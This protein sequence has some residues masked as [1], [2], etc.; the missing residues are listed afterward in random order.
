MRLPLTAVLP[1]GVPMK[2]DEQQKFIEGALSEPKPSGAI[3][4]GG[5]DSNLWMMY[6]GWGAFNQNLDA[7]GFHKEP[8]DVLLK[9]EDPTRSLQ[10]WTWSVGSTPR[11]PVPPILGISSR[12][13]LADARCSRWHPRRLM[14]TSNFWKGKIMEVIKR[15]NGRRRSTGDSGAH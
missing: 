3:C 2:M 8:V 10:P 4:Y 7:D 14:L 9:D 15:L 12:T 11:A 5:S 1:A 13:G 6:G